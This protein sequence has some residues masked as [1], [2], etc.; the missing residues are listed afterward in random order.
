M[1]N[2]IRVWNWKDKN[3]AGTPLE[4]EKKKKSPKSKKSLNVS[5]E[6]PEGEGNSGEVFEQKKK[7]S[8]KSKK[9]SLD[10]TK[11]DNEEPVKR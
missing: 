6:V 5:E 2:L 10:I 1:W 11:T 3:S 7:E 9:K 4:A 8:Q